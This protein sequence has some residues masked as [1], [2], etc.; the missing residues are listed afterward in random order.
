MS[1]GFVGNVAL[2]LSEGMAEALSVMYKR[3]IAKSIL[4]KIGFW[5]S[6][7]A[8]QN[9]MRYLDYAEHGGALLLGVKG[10]GI[11]CHGASSPKVIK[12]VIRIAVDFVANHVQERLEEG[13]AVFQARGSH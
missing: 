2:K 8:F 12:N 7:R 3:E 9:F 4:S 10:V 1:D 11:I 5:L 13:L 6:R